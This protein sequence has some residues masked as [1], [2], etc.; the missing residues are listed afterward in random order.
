MFQIF[1]FQRFNKLIN[2]HFIVYEN[3]KKQ[4]IE[5][6]VNFF[7]N[8]IKLDLNLHRTISFMYKN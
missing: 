1:D 5:I 8:K 7:K 2:Y 4:Q 6:L 3:Q